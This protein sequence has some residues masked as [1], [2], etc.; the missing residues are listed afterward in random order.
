[1]TVLVSILAAMGSTL[2]GG[3][4]TKV[5]VAPAPALASWYDDSGTTASGVHYRY[6]FASLLFGSE[7]GHH[8]EFYYRGHR[9]TGR[10]DDHGPYVSGRT[11]DLNAALRAALG[12]PDLCYLEWRDH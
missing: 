11:F 8:V 12:C 1:M 9:V 6:G 7:W 3:L 10:L 5:E 4:H 2:G